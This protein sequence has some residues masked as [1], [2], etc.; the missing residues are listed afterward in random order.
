MTRRSALPRV[1]ARL[2]GT[3]LAIE[4]QRLDAIAQAIGPRLLGDA[5]EDEP[6]ASR[7]SE[8]RP[9]RIDRD[10]I[11]TLPLHGILVQR[12][13]FVMPECA[14]LLGYDDIRAVAD[15]ALA[16]P[17]VKAI[18][19]DVDSPGGELAGVAELGAA[20]LR[21]R[22]TKPVWAVAN[23]QAYSAGYW[24][25]SAAQQVWLPATAGLGSIGVIAVHLDR[26]GL[27]AAAGLKFTAIYSGARKNDFTPHEPLS[28]EATAVLRAEVERAHGIFA[29]AVSQHRSKLTR[30]AVLDTEAGLFFGQAAVD[31][32]LADQVGTLAD[33]RAALAK[34]LTETRQRSTGLG[35]TQR[36]ARN[37]TMQ[38]TDASSAALET[39]AG[40][41]TEQRQ[42]GGQVVD[43]DALRSK[44]ERE[45]LAYAVE[46]AELCGLAGQP[47]L[48]AEFVK[49]QTPV[50]AVRK[51]LL[52]R[53]AQ[54]GDAARITN[55]H[56][57]GS[58]K[59]ASID[60]SA[61]YRARAGQ[62]SGGARA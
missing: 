47:A 3:P 49:S 4:A 24:L 60:T 59:R 46:V 6:D 19:L 30:Q 51:A 37:T 13:T 26:S 32:G 57:G 58:G 10:G 55:Q 28:R 2:F 31:A 21:A 43:L 42:E 35:T 27:E 9:Y 48:A 38:E 16:D 23:E 50:A 34:S 36:V 53:K 39:G 45:T 44:T 5:W 22:G 8:R 20:L 14:Y 1:A 7:Q 56:D 15:Q 11:V 61:I 25:A 52:E 29:D 62:T 18:L 17:A 33:A 41:T 54:E 40:A 12:G